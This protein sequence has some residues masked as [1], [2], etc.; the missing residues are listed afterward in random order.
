[1][2]RRDVEQIVRWAVDSDLEKFA[3]DAYGV[4]GTAFDVANGGDYLR[5]KFKQMQNNFIMFIAGLSESNRGRLARNITFNETE[6]G[7]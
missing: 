3:E 7:E 2:N 1:M 6:K 4:T 5:D